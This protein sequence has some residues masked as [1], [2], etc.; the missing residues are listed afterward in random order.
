MLQVICSGGSLEQWQGNF[1]GLSPRD[2]A[3]NVALPEVDGRVISRAISFKGRR[4]RH[5]GLETDIV[6]YEPVGDRIDF[7]ADLAAH[8]VKLRQ[9]PVQERR[10]A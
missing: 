2:L 1:K 5:P 4:S 8:W 6:T 10:I 7:V 9:T 3:M